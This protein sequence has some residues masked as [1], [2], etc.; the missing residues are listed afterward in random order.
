M[1]ESLRAE[2]LQR[3]RELGTVESRGLLGE[4]AVRLEQTKELAG[5]DVL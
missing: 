5:L 3:Q 4:R 2:I 1:D